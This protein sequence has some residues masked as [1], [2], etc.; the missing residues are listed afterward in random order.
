MSDATFAGNCPTWVAAP[1]AGL[2]GGYLYRAFGLTIASDIALPEL[3][4]SGAGPADIEIRLVE[5]KRDFPP[6]GDQGTFEFGDDECFLLYPQ[7]GAFRILPPNRIELE[8]VPDVDPGLVCFPLLGP[9]IALLLQARGA[10]LLHGSAVSV[11][12]KA[13]AFLGD[14]GAGKSTTACAFLRAGHR[15]LTDDIV[16]IEGLEHGGGRILPAFPQVKLSREASTSLALPDMQVRPKVPIV[17]DKERFLLG[18]GFSQEGL[19]PDLFFLLRRGERF[20]L[21]WLGP[22]ERMKA[23]LRFSYGTRFGMRGITRKV[24]ARHA[25][26]C[27]ALANRARAAILTVPHDL[28]RLP[29]AVALVEGEVDRPREPQR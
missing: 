29:E 22:E 24:A 10:F 21:E 8:L 27:P 3:E 18:L 23:F 14:K 2:A 6:P 17:L 12:G 1:A 11:L 5:R 9:V 20:D 13:V 15:L 25:R 16:A 19:P 26:Q 28:T 7:I 4:P